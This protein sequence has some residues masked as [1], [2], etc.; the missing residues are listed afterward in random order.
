MYLSIVVVGVPEMDPVM[1]LAH[2]QRLAP[3]PAVLVQLVQQ[4]EPATSFT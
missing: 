2:L 4:V 3:L 1:V